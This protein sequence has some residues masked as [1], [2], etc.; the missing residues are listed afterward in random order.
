MP[1]RPRYSLKAMLVFIAMLSV[2]LAMIG[3]RDETVSWLGVALLFP[4]LGG[5]LGCLTDT[6]GGTEEGILVG[7]LIGFA[8]FWFLPIFLHGVLF[9]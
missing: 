5:G 4:V 9:R 2:P 3:M 7:A 1:N 8:V 6:R